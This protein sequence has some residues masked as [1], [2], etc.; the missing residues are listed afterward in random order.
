MSRRRVAW[1]ALTAALTVLWVVAVVW[2]IRRALE[3]DIPW[4]LALLSLAGLAALGLGV[5][6]GAWEQAS[7]SR[8]RHERLS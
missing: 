7:R 8:A 3:G 5:V 6:G 2:R 4:P 1:I